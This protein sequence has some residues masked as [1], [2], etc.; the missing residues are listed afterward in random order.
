M[1][2]LTPFALGM[3]CSFIES[4]VEEVW[5]AI[6]FF[7]TCC[8]LL[9]AIVFQKYFI[10][11]ELTF[12]STRGSLAHVFVCYSLVLYRE[13]S[14]FK[15]KCWSRRLTFTLCSAFQLSESLVDFKLLHDYKETPY[16]SF[17]SSLHLSGKGTK[18]NCHIVQV[19]WEQPLVHT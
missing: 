2:D 12:N 18:G 1:N 6:F 13:K 9:P 14:Y 15:S 11:F 8:I 19:L 4:V 16:D 10:D 17:Q 3:M 5:M 7:S